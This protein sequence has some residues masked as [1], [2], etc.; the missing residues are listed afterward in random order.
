V[1]NLARFLRRQGFT[2]QVVRSHAVDVETVGRMQPQAI[3]LSPGPHRP[4]QA[5][6][7]LD[8]VRTW[9]RSIPLLGVCL[10][11]QTIGEAFGGEIV[12]SEPYHGRSS[13]IT[14][15]GDGLF[16]GLPQPLSVGRYHSLAIAS[17]SVPPAL[18]VTARSDDGTI[19][20]I[21]HR[22]WPIYGVQFHPESVLTPQGEPLLAN[23]CRLAAVEQAQVVL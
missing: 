22:Q 23:F 12:R 16:Q 14:H 5:G 15:D 1:H 17:D 2:T 18:R 10:G 8:V 6:C 11:H 4:P 20:G 21:A 13:L 7:C 19:M 9:G 3:V